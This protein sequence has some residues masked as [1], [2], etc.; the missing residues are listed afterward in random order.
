MTPPA[1]AQEIAGEISQIIG[2]HHL[3]GEHPSTGEL[4]DRCS[5]L[6][7]QLRGSRH[8]SARIGIGEQAY[9]L[10]VV[11]QTL[12][13]WADSGF[14]LVGASGRLRI[15]RNSLL[16]RLDKISSRLG[17]SVR[18]PRHGRTLYLAALADQLDA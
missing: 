13:A 14:N 9:H 5:R 8:A 2:V 4:H 11:R 7:A 3:G 15:H 17:R 10:A 1:L 6:L 18:E 16:H 12:I